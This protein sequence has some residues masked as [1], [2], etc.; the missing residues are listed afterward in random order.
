MSSMYV[1]IS[2]PSCFRSYMLGPALLIS[3]AILEAVCHMKPS[4]PRSPV[5]FL[6]L[7]SHRLSS[8]EVNRGL[9]LAITARA[10][11]KHYGVYN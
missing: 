10:T 3:A 7:T 6:W 2:A 11:S 9:H 1:C 5:I 8:I 4:S